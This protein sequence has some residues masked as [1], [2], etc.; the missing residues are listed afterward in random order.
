MVEMTSSKMILSSFT[1]CLVKATQSC[2][3]QA[4][5]LAAVIYQTVS[6]VYFD[7]TYTI[8]GVDAWTRKKTQNSICIFN[9]MV[10]VN[11]IKRPSVSM[12]VDAKKKSLMD[13]KK[14]TKQLLYI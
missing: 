10:V 2:T 1:L 7:I 4:F 12:G 6:F 13:K 11:L 9:G 5:S 14:N 3:Q 8:L